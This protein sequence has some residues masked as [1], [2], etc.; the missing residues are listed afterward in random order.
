MMDWKPAIGVCFLQTVGA[1][2]DGDAA[3]V[4]ADDRRHAW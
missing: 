4:L 2:E 3:G 1:E